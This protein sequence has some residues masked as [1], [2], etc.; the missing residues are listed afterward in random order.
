MMAFDALVETVMR[1][2]NQ[3]LFDEA[4][5]ARLVAH[6]DGK[7]FDKHLKDLKKLAGVAAKSDGDA[8]IADLS[9]AGNMR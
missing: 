2:H 6:D 1:L 4:Y 7:K 3:Q 5:T 9:R 8:M